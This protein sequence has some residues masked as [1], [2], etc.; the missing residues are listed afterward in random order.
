MSYDGATGQISTTTGPVVTGGS[1]VTT[2]GYTQFTG[3]NAPGGGA[4]S[5]SLAT[6]K[7]DKI[8]ASRVTVTAYGYETLANKLVPKSMTVD[9]G[10][11]NLQTQM[12]FDATG[13]MQ[14]LTDPRG[15]VTRY[16][17]DT[18]RRLV[19]MTRQVNS[20]DADCA[21]TP[22]PSGDDLV[23]IQEFDQDGLL[24]HVRVKDSDA[25]TWRDTAFTYTPTMLLETSLDPEGNVTRYDYDAVGHLV[26][27]TDP[28]GRKRRNFYFAD[29][30]LRK[31]LRGY[32]YGATDSNETC[33]VPGTDQVCEVQLT[34]APA[35]GLPENYNGANVYS[36]IDANGNATSY[37]FDSYDR[38]DR[39]TYADA[40]YDQNLLYNEAGSVRQ[41]RNRAG[42]IIVSE[43][44]ALSRVTSKTHSSF[45]AVTY[46]YDLL[47]HTTSVNQAGGQ[48]LSWLYD[49]ALRVE[50]ATAGSRTLGYLY[51]GSGNRRRIT[52]PD[53]YFVEYTYDD[54]NRMDQVKENNLQILADYDWD[55]LSR[56]KSLLRGNGDL[57][58]Y[59]YEADSDLT[60]ISQPGLPTAPVFDITRNAA[61]Q[62]RSFS[63]SDPALFWT[64]PSS[65][66]VSYTPN[67][68]NQ[69]ARVGT[70]NYGYDGKGNLTGDGSAT[71]SYDA[72]N[73]LTSATVAEVFSEY[74]YD[75]TGRR[76]SK[77]VGTAPAT[78]FLLDGNEEVAEYSGGQ[79]VRR[80]VYGV[81]I[82]E[83][84]VMYEG[85]GTAATDER[86]Y[87]VNHQ[88]S[89][90]AIAD[91]NG[92]VTET[93]KYS[94]FGESSSVTGNPFRFT[95]RRYDS[96][97]GLYFLRARYYS[98]ALGRFLQTDP[99]GTQDNYNLYS[100][101][102]NDPLN[103]TD[104]QGTNMV[105]DAPPPPPEPELPVIEVCHIYQV[106]IDG[107]HTI[108][109]PTFF[110]DTK[111]GEV[112]A[113]TFN[114][115]G[116][117][118]GGTNPITGRYLTPLELQNS[119]PELAL[120]VIFWEGS[121]AAKTTK[122]AVPNLVYRGLAAGE[123]PA[124]GLFARAPGA[125]NSVASHVGGK[126]A[127]EWISTT[128]SLEVA[129]SRFGQNGV[130][131]IDLNKVT[132]KVVD[133]SKGIPGLNPNWMLPKWAIK[134][135]EVLIQ[136]S[137]PA[138]AITKIK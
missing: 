113:S 73:R 122:E 74:K 14:S 48:M 115:V 51:D 40:S 99:T 10:G 11:F 9:S 110:K 34:Y 120:N 27:A 78:E 72:E 31:V 25:G 38:P 95:G 121:W 87:Y 82:D 129:T 132:N 49:T 137:V 119:V 108:Y 32:Q 118:N 67:S 20:L 92:A 4:T 123:D 36:T 8:D 90:V 117:V 76:I 56:R 50:S 24:T 85:G 44:D 97:T 128:K 105:P 109:E 68:L 1:P 6:S 30:K 126:Q 60:K 29:G 81:G 23:T 12:S 131:A 77:K 17:F 64:P 91:G 45:P 70:S 133:L 43:F 80:Y 58:S 16:C 135:Q 15:K 63:S 41:F 75:G 111:I 86:Y 53:G 112:I 19:R 107:V 35:G 84:I 55:T 114:F 65:G 5:I 134:T 124:V 102:D 136:N 66:T 47:S 94:P 83:R 33:A 61:H 101:V 79:L 26:M 21:S 54:A 3:L 28:A 88:G 18:G 93:A 98:P 100:Y 2:M 96:E 69:Y 116:L 39:T 125:G 46:G 89:T 62:I 106:H 52:W 42:E 127:T 103:A 13:N 22:T 57:T 138:N 7:T 130:V 59:G 104:P 71:Y 37:S